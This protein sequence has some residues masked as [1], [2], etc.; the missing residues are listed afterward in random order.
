MLYD[1]RAQTLVPHTCNKEARRLRVLMGM[2]TCPTHQSTILMRLMVCRLHPIMG[3]SRARSLNIT[4]N[5]SRINSSRHHRLHSILKCSR[6]SCRSRGGSQCHQLSPHKSVRSHSNQQHL[7]RNQ[8]AN[9]VLKKINQTESRNP[10]QPNL[11]ASS[12]LSMTVGRCW[13][14]IGVLGRPRTKLVA[15]SRAKRIKTIDLNRPM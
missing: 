1:V 12:L 3:N 5:R 6:L 8:S 15:T 9:S 13:P 10:P 14:N 11:G 2:L 7:H 4:L